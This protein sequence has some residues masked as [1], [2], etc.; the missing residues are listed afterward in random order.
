M[1]VTH[2]W[3]CPYK[4]LNDFQR[5]FFERKIHFIRPVANKILIKN[6]SR[7]IFG[8]VEIGDW[9]KWEVYLFLKMI[10]VSQDT[11]QELK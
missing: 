8:G 10:I 1:P 5:D 9:W 3:P 11:L 2:I 6:Y 4:T 7:L